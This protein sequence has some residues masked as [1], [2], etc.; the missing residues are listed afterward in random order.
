M[1]IKLYIN[2]HINQILSFIFEEESYFI[3]EHQAFVGE[4]DEWAIKNYAIING[5]KL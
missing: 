1:E 4:L 3:T 5:I 2:T